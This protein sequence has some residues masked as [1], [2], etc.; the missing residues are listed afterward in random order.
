MA[1][2]EIAQCTVDMFFFKWGTP[3]L[4]LREHELLFE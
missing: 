4:P 2:S 1:S 3:K